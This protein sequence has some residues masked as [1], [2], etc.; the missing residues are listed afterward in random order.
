[1]RK[2]LCFLELLQCGITIVWILNEVF[3]L[4]QCVVFVCSH[5]DQLPNIKTLLCLSN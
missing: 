3:Y 4:I 5:L 1:M 2:R